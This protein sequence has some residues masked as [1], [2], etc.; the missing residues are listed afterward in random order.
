MTVKRVG[1]LV[2]ELAKPG[3]EV[4]R[5]H[6]VVEVRSTA[7]GPETR[8]RSVARTVEDQ[9]LDVLLGSSSPTGR[10]LLA[11]VA[12]ILDV[13]L[14]L[15]C[16]DVDLAALTATKLLYS[17]KS[18]ATVRAWGRCPVFGLRPKAATSQDVSLTEAEIIISGGRGMGGG[19]SFELLR[20]CAKVLRAAVG[21]SRV[22]VDSG[23]VPHSMQVGLTGATVSP[24]L[25][26]A[27]GISGA[28]QHFAGM[29]TSG[30]LVAVNKDKNAPMMR[31]CDYGIVGDLFEVVP[32]L[33]R[34]LEALSG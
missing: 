22:A 5:D 7:D 15:D 28:A 31:G 27:C 14:V 32:I 20:E 18:L 10:D 1:V 19:E 25:Y 12:A 30:T 13:P 33:T 17:G 16:L 6:E 9:G 34:Q 2:E 29:G 21:A 3:A 24:R 23:W 4:L 11:R 26:I 8:A